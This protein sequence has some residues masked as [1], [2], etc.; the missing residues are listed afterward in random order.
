MKFR[1]KCRVEVLTSCES[2]TKF[3]ELCRTPCFEVMID[4]CRC[5]DD[6]VAGTYVANKVRK[7][8][9]SLM[10]WW[11]LQIDKSSHL[12]SGHDL[13]IQ[14]FYQTYECEILLEARR[15]RGTPLSLTLCLAS[16]RHYFYTHASC[17]REFL[18]RKNCALIR[19]HHNR[20]FILPAPL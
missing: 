16:A 7:D 10:L 15:L 14:A 13:H 20:K 17:C 9:E 12:N 2:R 3:Q 11:S 6:T 1:Y 5:E 8:A 18:S 19:Q 4:D